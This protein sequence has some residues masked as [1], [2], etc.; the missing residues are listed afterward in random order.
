[1]KEIKERLEMLEKLEAKNKEPIGDGQAVFMDDMTDEE[2]QDYQTMEVK[3]W[4]RFYDKITNIK[5][6]EL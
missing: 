1:M 5:D 2:F 6:E 3:G 4:K